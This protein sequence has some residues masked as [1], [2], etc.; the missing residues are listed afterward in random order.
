MTVVCCV[1]KKLC[2]AYSVEWIIMIYVSAYLHEYVFKAIIQ[3]F[4]QSSAFRVHA[5]MS[6]ECLYHFFNMHNHVCPDFVL[7]CLAG[8]QT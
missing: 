2:D 5:V 8:K 7:L 1:Y 6:T 4:I 3:P